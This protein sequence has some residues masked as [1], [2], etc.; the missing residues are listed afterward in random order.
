MIRGW[1]KGLMACAVLLASHADSIAQA[2]DNFYAGKNIRI[3]V[4]GGGSYEAYARIF[5]HYLPGYIPGKPSIV[6]QEMPGGGGMRAASFLYNIAPRDGTVLGAVHGAVITSPLLTPDVA[7]FDVTKFGWIGNAT[8]DVYIGYVTRA[9]KVQILEQ[10]KTQQLIIGGTS[11]GSNGIDMAVIG[12]EMFGLKLKIISGYKTSDETKLAMERG[13]IEG[14]VGTTL[15]SL[16]ASGTFADG[17]VHIIL[18]HGAKP[19]PELPDVPLFGDLAKSDV[20]RGVLDIMR[21]RGEFAKPYLAPPGMPVQRLE[22]LRKAFLSVTADAG[23]L[24][25]VAR[26]H[27]EYDAPTSGADLQTEIDRISRTPHAAIERLV[28]VLAT[29]N[30]GKN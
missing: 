19:H 23:F 2:P 29:Y 4:S 15:G 12:R 27:L 7:D 22:M 17:A 1:V 8:R 14:T 30:D 25:D 3:V 11:L 28:S 20:D 18:Q 9:S 16:K 24:A 21:V 26:Q 10:A 5:A 13:E 6:V